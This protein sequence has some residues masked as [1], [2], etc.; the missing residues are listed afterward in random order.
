[1]LGGNVNNGANAGLFYFNAN[2]A[3]SNSNWNYGASHSYGMQ[4]FPKKCSYRS[5]RRKPENWPS[6]APISRQTPNMGEVIGKSRRTEKVAKTYKHTFE[7]ICDAENIRAALHAAAKGKRDKKSVRGAL[8]R[9]DEVVAH[10]RRILTE[11]IQ[12]LPKIRNGHK[13]NDGIKAKKRIICHPSFT[14]QIIDHAII[15]I[16]KPHFMRSFYRWS[17]GS[18]PGR[19]QESMIKYVAASIR[20]ND[21]GA[22]Y[23][24]KFDVAKCFDTINADAIYDELKKYEADKRTLALLRYKLDANTVR[25][26][27]GKIVKG[28]V[29]IGV[30]TSP[31]LVNVALNCVDHCLKDECGMNLEVRF[32]DDIFV[33]HG[34]KRE[35]ERAIAAAE[36]VLARFG[37]RWKE[38]PVIRKWAYGDIGKVR[39]CG[40]QL[41][42]ETVEVRDVVFIRAVRT[43]N[44]IA[45]KMAR[46][47]RVTWYDAA[48]VI[49]YGGRFAAF[50]SW[51]AFSKNV[52]QGKVSYQSM[53]QKISAHDRLKAK[54]G[55]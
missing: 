38:R 47:V 39:F 49:S 45:R 8:A 32:M 40:V 6:K 15:Q 7:Q 13:V 16:I 37:L 22:K 27:D 30:Y 36:K 10:I 52:L 4:G 11:S 23:Y 55:K 2:N 34:N 14:E 12:F 17:C 1:M 53:R 35:L 25:H 9:E 48:K 41:T 26:P 3:P 31:W 33:T 24:V 20:R 21:S 5:S 51:N 43:V 44:R 42:R 29:P 50:E 54:G 28:G 18:I 46:K 19:G